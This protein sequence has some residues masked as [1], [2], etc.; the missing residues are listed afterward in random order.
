MNA[1]PLYDKF[2]EYLFRSGE[3]SVPT[4]F[5][6]RASKVAVLLDN[7]IS[8]VIS[9]VVDYSINS[10]SEARFSIECSD[11]SLEDLLELWL[12]RI[13]VNV[14]GV[15]TGLQE[16][17]KEYYKER[18]AA[19][20]LCLLSVSNWKKITIGGNS[21]TVPT[22]LWFVSGSSVW[23]ERKNEKYFKLGTDKY[24]LDKD[25]KKSL[26]SG[27]SEDIIIQKPFDRWFT[28]YPSPY[29]IKKGVYKN[30]RGLEVL[31][32]KGD[33]LITKV[34]P[35]LFVMEK[36]NEALA[37]QKNEKPDDTDL[38]TMVNTFKDAMK[39]F[40]NE[41][42][43]T[44]V[45]G[46]A[47][48]QKGS[49]LIPDLKGMLSE[50]LYR[51]GY[52][53]ILSGLGF[54]S[55]VQGV[56]QSRKE[57]VINPK[58]FV[59]EVNAGVAGFKSI[60]MDVIRLI[61]SENKIDHKKLFSINNPLRVVSTPL[62][63]NVEQIIDQIR[64]GFV[65]GTI[66]VKT[67]QEMLGIDTDQ[68]LERMRKEWELDKDGINLRQIYYPHVISNQEDKGIDTEKITPITKKQNE[69]QVEKEKVPPTMNKAEVEEIAKCSKCGY[70]FAYLSVPEAGMGWVKC[71]KCE[72]AVSQEDLI[73]APY[74]SIEELLSKHPTMKKYP[75]GALKVFIE[76]FNSILKE[77]K[78]ERRAFAGAWSK[79]NKWMDRHGNKKI[80]E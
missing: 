47:F 5:H 36:G 22:V 9:T 23:I 37:V 50:E 12:E 25:F 42:A 58:P 40:N 41:G 60:L 55:V 14:D 54:V 72:E 39:R 48:D 10:A 13:N 18:W 69:K 7:D 19:S 30:W 31:Q 66:S 77:T 65:Y 29:L 53:A 2:I 57:E 24:F 80:N 49:H 35:Y 79:L 51:Q 15:P 73:I 67:Y 63:I 21:I 75:E 6:E 52:R 11:Q 59:A 76:V 70:E 71:P 28:K 44:P 16:L 3:I 1:L 74:N 27:E 56:G 45:A 62:R 78:N 38:Q 43:K 8:G 4:E 20:S 34:L 26:P 32:N 33:E 68:E 17:A 46:W 64:S 61:I